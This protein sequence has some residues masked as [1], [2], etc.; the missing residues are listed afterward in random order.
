MLRLPRPMRLTKRKPMWLARP[1]RLTRLRPIKP[2]RPLWSMRP[3]MPLLLLRLMRLIWP[4]R[5]RLTKFLRPKAMVR[6]K[7]MIRPKGKLRLK[8]KLRP[9]AMDRP[10][11]KLRPKANNGKL[12]LLIA[13]MM[14]LPSFLIIHFLHSPSQNTL[15]SLQKQKDILD[16]LHPAISMNKGVCASSKIRI[17]MNSTTSRKS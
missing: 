5:M 8:A 12:F 11:A 3:L 14:A 4:T 17:G 10:K 9:K 7:A 6:P 15:Q 1:T 13:L 2:M 16:L